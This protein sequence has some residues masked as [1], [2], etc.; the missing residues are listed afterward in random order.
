VVRVD[1]QNRLLPGYDADEKPGEILNSLELS[2][3]GGAGAPPNS[4]SGRRFGSA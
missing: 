2:P 3:T 4:M 1:A